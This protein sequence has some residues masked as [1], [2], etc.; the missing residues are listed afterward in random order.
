MEVPH[1]RP[2]LTVWNL[3]NGDIKKTS[4]IVSQLKVDAKATKDTTS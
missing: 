3:A 1:N 2:T 4:T